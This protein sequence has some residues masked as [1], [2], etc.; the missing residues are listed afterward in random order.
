MTTKMN[1]VDWGGIT[2][3][4]KDLEVNVDGPHKVGTGTTVSGADLATLANRA[5]GPVVIDDD[6]TYTVLASNSG[7]IHIVPE[8]T[9]TCTITLPAAEAGLEYEFWPGGAAAD[10]Q[11]WVFVPTAGFFI[12]GL[13]HV[14][15]GGTTAALYSNGSSNDVFTVVTPGA[16]TCIRF[17]C[18]GTNW[19][20]NGTL[21]SA[22]IGT[23]ADS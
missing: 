15:I 16:G 20:V 1:K 5:L 23:M 10:A 3:T 19:Y 22:T 11:N 17:R 8:L 4:I 9:A 14:D 6:T 18:D 7:R 12:G 2:P 21:S 13:S